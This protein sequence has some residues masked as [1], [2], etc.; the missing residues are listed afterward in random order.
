L[1]VDSERGWLVV[2][3]VRLYDGGSLRALEGT[4]PD[5]SV[6]ELVAR[7]FGRY[8]APGLAGIH[9]DFAVVI[10]NARE[11]RVDAFRDQMGLVPLYVRSLPGGMA[12]GS[13]LRCLLKLGPSPAR[14]ELSPDMAVAFVLGNFRDSGATFFRA[15]RQ[16]QAGHHLSATSSGSREAR[17]WAPIRDALERLTYHDMIEEWRR[18]FYQAVER[19]LQPDVPMA[20]YLSGGLDSGGIVG[21]AHRSYLE[22]GVTEPPMFL[23]SATFPGLDCDESGLIAEAAAKSPLFKSLVW[24]GTKANRGDWTSPHLAMPG[25]RRG[26]G[27]GPRRD[28][29]LIR[30]HGIRSVF[31]GTG[32]D[33]LGWSHGYFHDLVARRQIRQLAEELR[34]MGSWRRSIYHLRAS[35]DRSFQ[36]P[37]S[38]DA[39][40]WFTPL[41]RAQLAESVRSADDDGLS[42]TSYCQQ[43]TWRRLTS[44]RMAQSIEAGSLVL[45]DVGA[46]LRMPYCD[47]KLV[48]FV[49]RIP[50]HLRRPRGDMR[51]VQRDAVGPFLAP[52]VRARR[53]KALA[54][55]ALTHHMRRNFESFRAVLASRS[56]VSEPFFDRAAAEAELD[57]LFR[58]DP[59]MRRPGL[60][61]PLWQLGVFEA[62]NQKR[63]DYDGGRRTMMHHADDVAFA[64]EQPEAREES[65]GASSAAAPVGRKRYQA[66]SLV[67]VGNARNLLAG[68]T[69][70][71][72]DPDP[73]GVQQISFNG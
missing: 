59:L 9:G 15:I 72:L 63:M 18:L 28:L 5:A 61:Q 1:F 69:G 4:K 37:W 50:W 64:R 7:I 52:A 57:R 47:V 16:V 55:A 25:L 66:P 39:P 38:G 14:E 10:W 24:D 41:S 8:G 29:S 40:T 60:W 49:L 45:A 51:R 62:W 43:E 23:L 22:R 6:L 46:E 71:S 27:S 34:M 13:D 48:E 58:F 42:F 70:T 56:W 2:G 65:T 21:A 17:Y 19:R 67:R 33:E 32:G 3:H 35:F 26:V 12:F 36:M 53:S 31:S 20:S 11:R 44:G 30:T 54:G 68:I 73:Q